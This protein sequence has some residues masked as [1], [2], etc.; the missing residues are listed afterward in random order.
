MYAE[1]PN[2]SAHKGYEVVMTDFKDAASP[3]LDIKDTSYVGHLVSVVLMF[4]VACCG[5]GCCQMSLL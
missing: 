5:A 3:G 1:T 4:W 2:M